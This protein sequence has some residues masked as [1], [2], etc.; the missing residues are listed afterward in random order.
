MLI[1][2]FSDGST[3]Q[4]LSQVLKGPYPEIWLQNLIRC[5]IFSV[6]FSYH[7]RAVFEYERHSTLYSVHDTAESV[8]ALSC[9][10]GPIA[11]ICGVHDIAVSEWLIYILY[12]TVQCVQCTVYMYVWC[13]WLQSKSIKPLTFLT[14]VGFDCFLW[15][16]LIAILNV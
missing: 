11:K 4:N 2:L 14:R 15:H 8:S 3:D 5:K 7:G 13:I 6:W 10:H 1:Y 16:S 12:S 9:I